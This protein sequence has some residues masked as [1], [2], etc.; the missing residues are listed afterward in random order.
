MSGN[1]SN[2]SSGGIAKTVLGAGGGLAGIVAAS[3][4]TLA[5][6]NPFYAAATAALGAGVGYV[7]GTGLY[8]AMFNNSKPEPAKGH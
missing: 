6:V 5:A 1:S 4:L 2:G 3:H 7:T 8:R